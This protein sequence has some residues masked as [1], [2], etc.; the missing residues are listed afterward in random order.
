MTKYYLNAYLNDQLVGTLSQGQLVDIDDYIVNNKINNVGDLYNQIKSQLKDR[1]IGENLEFVIQYEHNK[2]IKTVPIIFNQELSYYRSCPSKEKF[3]YKKMCEN[4]DFKKLF[5][6]KFI[7]HLV[8]MSVSSKIYKRVKAYF[9]NFNEKTFGSLYNSLAINSKSK[10]LDSKK[11]D[12][13]SEYEEALETRTYKYKEQRNMFFY[14]YFFGKNLPKTNVLVSKLSKD[15][16]KEMLNDYS[17][18]E[19][20]EQMKFD[21][22][23]DDGYRLYG[24]SV[25]YGEIDDETLNESNYRK[26]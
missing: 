19:F 25:N 4:D 11:F 10:N 1:I 8:E 14:A 23:P 7:N 22:N 13:V 6:Y 20:E 2:E 5:E 17:M 26:L 12:T 24:K 16:E 18:D 21:P 3:I 9:D 15:K